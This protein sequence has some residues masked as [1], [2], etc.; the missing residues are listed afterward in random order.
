MQRASVGS[1][2]AKRIK[3]IRL[4]IT[5]LRE[6]HDHHHH[7][8][9]H[10]VWYSPPGRVLLSRRRKFPSIWSGRRRCFIESETLSIGDPPD[11]SPARGGTQEPAEAA[12]DFVNTINLWIVDGY[13]ARDTFRPTWASGSG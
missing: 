2:A 10:T 12:L 5:R 6:R 13:F 9:L 11:D 7:L 1:V 3:S 8:H 4:F